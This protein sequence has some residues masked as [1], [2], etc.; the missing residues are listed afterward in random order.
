MSTTLEFGRKSKLEL[1]LPNELLV[2]EHAGPRGQELSD[3]AAA[4]RSALESPMGLPSIAKMVIPDDRVVIAIEEGLPEAPSLFAGTVLTLAAMGLDPTNITGIQTK[5]HQALTRDNLANEVPPALRHQLRLVVHDPRDRESLSYL[6]ASQKQEPIYFH[7]EI[8]DAD[9][10]IPIGCQRTQGSVADQGGFGS[11]FPTYADAATQER[12]YSPKSAI[13]RRS[14]DARLEEIKEA[15]WLLGVTF[16]VRVIAGDKGGLLHVLSGTATAVEQEG[17][18]LC[19]AAWRFPISQKAS[20][21]LAG[22]SGG[23]EQQTW[24]N[25]ARSLSTILPHIESGGA[26]VICSD[27]KERPGR[28]L[29][30]LV[31]ANSLDHAEQAIQKDRTADAVTAQLL[32]NAL[33]QARVY[34]LCKLDEETVEDLGMAYVSEAKELATLSRQHDSCMVLGNAHHVTLSLAESAS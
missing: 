12:F 5:A 4:V 19:D 21:V 8:C 18:R 10:V 20:L 22:I 1:E 17:L 30:R 27:L 16:F 11:L 7:R 24:M 23:R 32:I 3:V 34:L 15:I 31:G 33:R 2:A 25:V 9:F 13:D 29:R 28:S 14:R 6:A 26:I